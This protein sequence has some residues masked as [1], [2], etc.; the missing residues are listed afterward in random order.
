MNAL[1]FWAEARRRRNHFFL[2]WIGWL[3]VGFPLLGVWSLIFGLFGVKDLR[4]SGAAA[5]F[6]WFAFFLW[7]GQRLRKLR[8]FRCGE[9]AFPKPYFFMSHAKCKNCGVKYLDA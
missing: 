8:C 4:A 5:L 2:T 6:T 9:R 3:V 7:V 1:E